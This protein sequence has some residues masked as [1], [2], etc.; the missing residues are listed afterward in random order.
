MLVCTGVWGGWL[1]CACVYRCVGRV[2]NVCLCVQVCEE[3]G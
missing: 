3:G 1:M 2:V